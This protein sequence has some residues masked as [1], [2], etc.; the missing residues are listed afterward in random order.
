MYSLS[1]SSSPSI[2]LSGVES[3]S[4]TWFP[5]FSVSSDI[6][7]E[8]TIILSDSFGSITLN[9]IFI[10]ALF[11]FL[12]EISAIFVFKPKLFFPFIQVNVTVTSA[13]SPGC[14]NLFSNFLVEITLFPSSFQ[15]G[16][17]LASNFK[18][19]GI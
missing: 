14:N 4:S 15:S 6:C 3:I 12:S 17:S 2:H 5:F 11:G 16:L 7:A 10:S 13:L 19:S 18:P 9:V 8:F 1:W